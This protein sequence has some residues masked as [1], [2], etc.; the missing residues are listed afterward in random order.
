MI[1]LLGG[2]V[3]R[4]DAETAYQKIF[5]DTSLKLITGAGTPDDAKAFTSSGETLARIVLSGIQDWMEHPQRMA[6]LDKAGVI[7]KIFDA[8][9][10]EA[11]TKSNGTI[12]IKN[13]VIR[14]MRPYYRF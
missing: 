13:S 4:K 2:G 11:Y 12:R 9:I 5:D 1:E 3:A 14:M 8:V 7:S 6:I 10:L